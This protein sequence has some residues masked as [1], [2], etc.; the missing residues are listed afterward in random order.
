[1]EKQQELLEKTKRLAEE[2]AKAQK[3]V[4]IA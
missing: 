2:Q 1:M 3:E 4:E